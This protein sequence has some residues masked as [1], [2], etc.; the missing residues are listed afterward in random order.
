MLLNKP[1][2]IHNQYSSTFYQICLFE[3]EVSKTTLK[4]IFGPLSQYTRCLSRF[5][6]LFVLGTEFITNSSLIKE[7]NECVW[8]VQTV[9]STY[10]DLCSNREVEEP[11]ENPKKGIDDFNCYNFVEIGFGS[12]RDMKTVLQEYVRGDLAENRGA[13]NEEL[14]KDNIST[15]LTEIR[16]TFEDHRFYLVGDSVFVIGKYVDGWDGPLLTFFGVGLAN[17]TIDTFL[18]ISNY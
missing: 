11:Q 8:D 1:V 4:H 6:F 18:R 2:Q 9:E 5:A 16:K 15:F 17:K 10:G 7:R 3:G 14:C 13:I 12:P